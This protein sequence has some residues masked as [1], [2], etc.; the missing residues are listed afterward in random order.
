MYFVVGCAP[1]IHTD[2]HTIGHQSLI[3]FLHQPFKICAL[4]RRKMFRIVDG[5][6]GANN[7]ATRQRKTTT[8]CH[9]NQPYRNQLSPKPRGKKINFRKVFACWRLHSSWLTWNTGTVRQRE[10]CHHHHRHRYHINF[11]KG[12]KLHIPV[13]HQ[14]RWWCCVPFVRV[15]TVWQIH[16]GKMGDSR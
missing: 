15:V 8:D 11:E 1:H 2:T 14:Q 10:K 4:L 3:W 9:R 7:D 6:N 12:N 13:E 5:I 16:S